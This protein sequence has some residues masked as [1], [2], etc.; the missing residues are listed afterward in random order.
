MALFVSFEG[1]EGTGKTTQAEN[2]NYRLIEAG[3]PSLLIREPGSTNLG[4]YIRDL[5][6]GRP[7]GDNTISREAELLLF[8]ASRAELV[9]KVLK[10]RMSE[11]NLVIIADRYADS[12]VAYQGYGRRLPLDLV[13]SV[14]LLATGGVMPHK[15]FLLDCPP[16]AGLE[17][18]GSMQADLFDMAN[19]G[20][21]DGDDSRRFEEESIHFHKRVHAGYSNMARSEPGRWVVLDALADEEDIAD[22]IWDSITKM[23]AFRSMTN[24]EQDTDERELLIQPAMTTTLL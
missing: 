8:A 9:G 15:T 7:W 2:L 6:K 22:S 17:R 10:H 19:I 1:G 12:T 20:R 11:P 3:I 21:L 18:V 24:A 23:E 14:N 16:E 5:I 4:L 13:R